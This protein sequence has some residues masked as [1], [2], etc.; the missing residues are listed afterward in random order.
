[1]IS[2]T[3]LNLTA[4]VV[5]S[6]IFNYQLAAGQDQL[7]DATAKVEA[8]GANDIVYDQQRDVLYASIKSSADALN[9]NSIV[10]LDPD[11]L[12]VLDRT[13][14]GGG[15]NKLAISSDS[16]RLYIGVDDEGA[17]RHLNLNN[18]VLSPI[19]VLNSD[20]STP[21]VA[22]A[23][24]IE[25]A[26]DDPETVI[27]S[28]GTVGR[29]GNKIESFNDAGKTNDTA[30]FESPDTIAFIGSDT[31]VGFRNMNSGFLLSRFSFDGTSLTLEQTRNRVITGFFTTIEASGGLIYASNGQIL[32]PFDLTLVGSFGLVDDSLQARPIGELEVSSI[33]G[34]A[35]FL[36]GRNLRVFDTNSFLL[37][38]ETNLDFSPDLE[39]KSLSYA[40]ENRLAFVTA[41]GDVGIISEIQF[42]PKPPP[43]MIIRGTAADD[44]VVFDPVTSEISVNGVITPVP[45]ETTSILF[46]G[47]GGVDYVTSIGD[48][49]QDELAVLQGS[50]MT[51]RGDNYF[52]AA[53]DVAEL[54]F[55]SG[56]GSD[57]AVIFDS[58]A[59]ERLASLPT[60]VEL[61]GDTSL[62][63]ATNVEN[64][65]VFSSGGDDSARMRGGFGSERVNGNMQNR[66][67][68]MT[69]DDFFVALSG[70]ETVNA[71]GGI[72]ESDIATIIDSN[73]LEIVFFR[74]DFGRFLNET[75]DYSVRNFERVNF[76]SGSGDDIGVFQQT[77]DSRVAGN[78]FWESLIGPDFRNNT[79]GLGV[80]QVR[81]P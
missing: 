72:G 37:L 10:I 33:D 5:F 45:F 27:V 12:E 49:N 43:R 50:V 22:I 4:F 21:E 63:Q 24:D 56:S 13:F 39:I 41:D 79:F 29:S 23:E 55:D 52:F 65:F 35:Y 28:L 16:S 25:V 60:S 14:V 46:F 38:D 76:S 54:E 26:P 69:G 6:L 78:G 9:E 67:M 68:R 20:A 34:F 19:Q 31:L 53:R 48:P 36:N 7:N 62:L 18:G 8:L 59:E 2:R 40:G 66:Q 47:E 44:W 70:F 57:T 15:P 58:E 64:V 75:T 61:S 73:D 3:A 80:V 17:I 51:V 1:M 11:T 30:N 71:N 42:S 81:E 74:G 32:N 77:L